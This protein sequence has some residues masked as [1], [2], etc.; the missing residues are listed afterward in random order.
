MFSCHAY[1]MFSY[2]AYTMFSYHAY[3]MFSYHTYTMLTMF[4]IM[5]IF[6]AIWRFAYDVWLRESNIIGM[7]REY[8]IGGILLA[9]WRPGVD[10]FL[11]VA[12]LTGAEA[13]S[14]EDYAPV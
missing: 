3:T 6:H 9:F 8:P 13:W 2:H 4:I 1:T 11:Q 14:T 7:G 12:S 5:F 10:P